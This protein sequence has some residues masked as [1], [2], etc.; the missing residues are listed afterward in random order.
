MG[1]QII[2]DYDEYHR[3]L[4]HQYQLGYE[5]KFRQIN[6]SLM[7]L[8]N[9]GTLDRSVGFWGAE[10]SPARNAQ[11]IALQISEQLRTKKISPWKAKVFVTEGGGFDE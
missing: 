4:K 8:L 9:G 11:L 3:E 1:K 6:D 7:A 10:T 5:A 2:I